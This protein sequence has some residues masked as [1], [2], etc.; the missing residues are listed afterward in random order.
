MTQASAQI[1]LQAAAFRADPYPTYAQLRREAPVCRTKIPGFGG[2]AWLVTRYDDVVAALK[3]ARLSSDMIAL[4]ADSPRARWIP[5]SFRILAKTMVTMDDPDHARLRT[6]VHKGFTPSMIESMA[7]RVQEIADELLARLE[8]REVVD[9]LQEFALA[10]PMIVISEMLGVPERER[11]KFR[12]FMLHLL[13]G[14][15]SG[16]VRL[17]TGLWN[18]VRMIRYLDGLIDLKRREPDGRLIAALVAAEQGGDRLSQDELVGMVFL[19]LLA[20]HETTVNLLGNG[21]L[22]LLDNPDQLARLRAE[23]GLIKPAIEELLRYTN[24]VQHSIVRHAKAD[25]EIGGVK[26]AKS[27]RVVLMLAAANR[28]ERIF[29]D[30]ESLDIARDPNRHLGFGLGIHFCLGA[31]LARMEGAIALNALLQR[32]PEIAL[33]IPR[34]AVKWRRNS[35]LR[36][37]ATLPIRLGPP[38]AARAL[39]A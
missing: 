17:V 32:F 39:A 13:D 33:A 23:P 18:N 11:A 27:D 34:N 21:I 7:G 3:D 29:A 38:K 4:R 1:D 14:P 26:I 19:L 6:L 8:G 24:P 9:L 37:L 12:R 2:E 28:D 16:F 20:G 25:M 35:L 36:G 31:P 15:P 10:L 5:R 22:A 30:S